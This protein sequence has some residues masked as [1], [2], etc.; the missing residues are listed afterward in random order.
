MKCTI[1]TDTLGNIKEVLTLSGKQSQLFDKA[2]SQFL[3][4]D[5]KDAVRVIPD[6]RGVSHP[7]A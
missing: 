1:H 5:M 4:S 2:A 6:V 3:F 7:R